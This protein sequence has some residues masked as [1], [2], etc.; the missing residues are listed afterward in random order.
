MKG[1][2]RPDTYCL[3]VWH[4]LFGIVESE[5][6][7][8]NIDIDDIDIDHDAY[9][10]ELGERLYNWFIDNLN[11]QLPNWLQFVKTEVTIHSPKYYNYETDSI[12]IL[13]EVDKKKL[14]D[15][16]E[17]NKDGIDKYLE[18]YKSRD[19]FISF[20]P[21]S[22]SELRNEDDFE[23]V[24]MCVLDYILK[25]IKL[26]PQEDFDYTIVYNNLV[27]PTKETVL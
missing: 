21:S 3:Y 12:N 27:Y 8:M 16:V 2:F 11:E 13:L 5:A 10:K 17:N 1:R 26:Y 19:W 14:L 9:K 6:Y 20:T 15:Y 22:Y 23:R 18:K 25:D 4:E 7:E 24:T